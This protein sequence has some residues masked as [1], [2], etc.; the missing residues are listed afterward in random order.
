MVVVKILMPSITAETRKPNGKRMRNRKPTTN[1]RSIV[2]HAESSIMSCV[3]VVGRV[4][5]TVLSRYM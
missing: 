5:L 2:A 3:L 4:P 1:D